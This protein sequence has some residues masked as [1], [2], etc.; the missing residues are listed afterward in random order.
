MKAWQRSRRLGGYAALVLGLAGTA[1]SGAGTAQ[2][3]VVPTRHAVVVWGGDSNFTPQ[4]LASSAG[5][6]QVSAGG[7]H[8]LVLK[9]DGT[10][11]ARGN[12][13]FGQL[14]NGT[15]TASSTL[16]QVPGLTGVV[17][18]SAGGFH[19]L[20]LRSDGTVW[21][22]GL[23]GPADYL[24]PTE[25]PGLTGV[26]KIAGGDGFSLA[27]RSDGTVWAWGNNYYGD[28]GDGTTTASSVPVQVSGLSQVTSIAAGIDS[29]LAIRTQGITTIKTVWAWGGNSSGQLGD[30]TLGNH[31]TPEQVTGIKAPSV[32]GISVGQK[33]AVAL[34]SD[35]SVWAWG[36]DDAGQLGNAPTASPVT[37][38]VET[39]GMDSG[40]TQV[41]AGANHVLALK[42]NG[43]VLAWGDNSEGEL[44]TGSTASVAGAV[45]VSGLAGVTQVSAGAEYSL[46]I[47]PAQLVSLPSQA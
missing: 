15:D 45:Q 36:A 32:T 33:F 3:G 14:G 16:I 42:S 7:A 17:Q 2:A 6:V 44:G 30:G 24:T 31:L 1:L 11:W 29:A 47:H 43:T 38:P 28:L 37:R 21:E 20:A 23:W 26:T 4:Q 5:V 12:N 35:G 46:A 10:V 41:S 19:S 39:T 22:W 13:W 18:V 25:V 27:L 8:I 40:I 34:G 9:S